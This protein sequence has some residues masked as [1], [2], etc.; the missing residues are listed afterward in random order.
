MPKRVKP[1]KEMEIRAAKHQDKTSYLFDGGGLFLEISS[2]GSKLWRMK[3]LFQGKSRMLSMGVYPE[4]SLANARERR[5]EARKLIA[6]G[7][8]PSDNRRAA[9]TARIEREANS[10][11]I[12]AREWFGKYAPTKAESHTSK[13][14]RCFER[15]IFP[16]IGTKPIAEINPPD[17]LLV[18]RRIENRGAVETAHRALGNISRV[19]RYAI[20][21]SRTISDPCR[22]LRGACLQ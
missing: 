18:L 22:D 3:Y 14:R 10:F 13:I 6:S 9:K 12:V 15:D 11:E 19:F 17:I 20:S 1:L 16:W 7:V 21:T 8:D 2:G 4:V 5:E